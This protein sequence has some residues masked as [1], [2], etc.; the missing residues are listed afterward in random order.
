[1]AQLAVGDVLE[2]RYRID[3]PIARGG[4]SMVYRCVDL[5]L[6]RAVAAK[7]M[8]D[9][10]VSDPVFRQRF[11]REARAMAQLTHPNLVNVYDFGSDG[12]HLFLIM[13]LITGGT[14]RE[15]LAERGPMP[16]HAAAAVMRS[17][18]TGLSAAH[19]S[20][21]V[22][23][24]IKPDNVLINGDHRV[25]LAD[26]GLVRTASAST[27][28]TDQ[29]V[30][31]VAYLSPEQVDGSD[32]TPASD[33]Y[34]AGIVLFELLTGTTPF[35]GDTPLAHAYAR[36]N[37]DVPAPSARIAGIPPLVDALVATATSR[38]PADRF[39]DATEFLAALDDVAGDLALPAFTVPV[40]TNSAAHR[41][42]AVPTDITDLVGPATGVIDTTDTTDTTQESAPAPVDETAVLEQ[43]P[44]QPLIQ[45]PLTPPATPGPAV[46]A[47]IPD[48]APEE[49]VDEYTPEPEP[50][51][52]PVS[53]RSTVG[54]FLWLLVVAIITVA[55]ALGAWW[56]GSGRYGEIPQVLGMD[57]V[58]AVAA[59]EEAGFTPATRII[60]S[61]DVPADQIA[62]TDPAT[63]EKLVRG[64][65]VTVLV[66]QG[67]PTVPAPEG[68][69]VLA[70]QE[71]ASERTL[72]VTTGDPVYSDSV[73][74]GRIATTDPAVGAAVPIGTTVTVHVSRGPEP[75][76]VPNLKG[77]DLST[78][79]AELAGLGLTVSA[80]EREYVEDAPGGEVLEVSPPAGTTLTRGSEVTLTVS[81]ALTV[82][83]VAGMDLDTARSTLEAAGFTVGDT[84]R[85]NSETAASASTVVETSPAAGTSTDPEDATVD[86]VLPGKV[87]VPDVEG[88]TV[89]QARETLKGVGLKINA[90]E[91][92]DARLITRQRPSAGDDAR[93]D[94]TVRVTLER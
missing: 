75:I 19:A 50:A 78:A 1:M 88:M 37:G 26:F 66:S 32:I 13:E 51:D 15:L 85:D 44:P 73:T 58:A 68:M 67:Q 94:S 30:G 12:D 17:V 34:S 76:Q 92:D 20:G 2:D 10:Y 52:P 46:S 53:N 57:R 84:D 55:V 24:D 21:L 60:Y 22:H 39:A 70:Y 45:P 79:E 38:N 80:V 74:E 7:V 5:R 31:T 91:R 48:R 36:I 72:E 40:P 64:E 8:D 61:D 56:F 14:L 90:R 69:D 65:E 89:A 23:R 49:I 62:G 18:L 93:V 86:I 47:R 83:D 9:R 4:M 81:N 25:K 87:T 54:L 43:Q 35:T 71:A 27:H 29:I 41:A 33:V 6:G 63:G 3:H 11:R 16:P 28:S 77:K 59:V 82:P 42:A